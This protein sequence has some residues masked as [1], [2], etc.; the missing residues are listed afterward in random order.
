MTS[1]A[2][3]DVVSVPDSPVTTPVTLPAIEAD[4]GA[5]IITAAELLANASDPDT[6]DI[7]SVT[8]VTIATGSGTLVDNLNGTWSYTPV[9][10]DTTA[11][12]FSYTVTDG[13]LSVTGSASL[14]ITPASNLPPV[15]TSNGGA[16]TAAV[17]VAENSTAVTTVT[18]TDADAGTTLTYSISGG[19]DADLF[20]I[21]ASGV[22]SFVSAP[23]FEAPTD[24]GANNVYDVQVQV[25]DGSL[26]DTQDIAVTVTNVVE[27]GSPPVITSNGGGPTAAVSVAE[28]STAVTTVT[29]TD[30]DAGATLTYSI[31]GGADADLFA[32]N[33]SGVLSFVSAPDF[34][35]PTDAGGNN[36]YDVQ[37]QV[38][39]G[40]LTDTQDIAVTVTNLNDNAPVITSNGGAATAAVNVAENSTAV[41]TVTATDADAGTTLTYSI[42]GGADADL[43]AINASGVLSFVS[44]PDFEAPTDAG[45]NNVYDVQ[46]QVSDGSLTDTQDIAVTV[47]NLNDNAPVITSNGGAATAA[48][49]VAE[50]STA[51]TTVTATDADAGT[52]LTYS[53]SGGADA[54]LFAINASGVLSFVSAPDFEAPTDAGANNVYDV[55]V[56]VSDGSLTDT[57]DIAVTVTNLNDNAPVITSNG[58]AAT[59]AVNVAENSTAVTTVTATDA[60]AGT[61]LTY[62]ISG[63]ADADLFTINASGVL[64]FV[65]APDFEAP[66]DAGANNV[67]DVQ[68]QVSDG[69]LTDTQDIAV[70]VTNV[71]EVGS[72]PVITSNGGG[73][74]AA[75]SVAENSTAVTTVTATD[76]DAGATLTYSISGGADADQFTINATSGVLSFVS[77]PDFEAPT[78]AGANNV[79][80]VQVQVSDGSL[81]DTQDIAV[82]VTNLNDNAP[83]ITSNGGAATAAVNVAENSTAVTTVTA[84]DADAGTTL[85][86]SISG[87]A[88]ADL[89]TINASGVL[90][91][92]SAPDFE[93]PT[94][95]GAN[96]V[97]D[98]QVQVSD[99]SLTDTQDIAVTVT[100]VVEVGSPPVITSNGGGPTAAVSVAEN[101]TAVTTVTATDADAG[102]TLTYSIS[103]GADADQFTINATSGVL[104][105]VSAPDFEAPT[106]AGANNVYDVQVQVSDGSLTDTQD[107]AVTVTN[108]NDNAPVITSNGGAATAAVN[109]AENSTAVTTVTATDADA[110][111]TLTYSISGGADAD[112]FT[113]NASGVLSF[114]SAPDF[115]A[116]TD[117][118]ANNVYDVQ[119][120]VSD[121][122]LT[123]TQD[124]A[125]TV[126]NLN[127]NAPVITSNGGAATAAVNVAENS[128]AVT[129][130]TATDADAGATLTYSISG[131]ADA[132][133]FTINATSGVLSFVSAPDFEAPTDAGANNVYDVQ[134]Q[135]SDGSLT[136]TQD[137]AVTVTNVVEVG[138]P[139]VITSNGG[140]PTAAVS[141]AEN[142]TAVTTVTATDADAGA[143]LTYSISGG[144]DADL[145]AINAERCPELCLG[146]GLRSPHRRRRQQRL[147]RPGPGLGWFIDRHPGHRRHRHQPQRQCPGD[148][149]QRRRRDRRRQCRREQ[150]RRHH[151]DRHRRRCRRH[152]DL[153]DQRRRRCRPVHHQCH[154]RC[155]ELCLG[156]GLRSPHRR[157]RQQR[158]RRPGPGLGW[159]ID[160]HPGH[161]RHRHQ[162]QRQCPGDHLQRR[163]RDRR[164]QR[165]REQ[166]RRHHR[167]RH[168]RRCR[169]HPDL[170]DQRRR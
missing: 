51:V 40:S 29:A 52:T 46:V 88:D 162:P 168:R 86:Y 14:D 93:A 117:A 160:R 128:T 149:L 164:R 140:G 87:G 95:A 134:V 57:Q 129:T 24:A 79:Y 39:D 156:S 83:V 142:S 68:V 122:S 154:E 35:A 74:T 152:P 1:T 62:S 166:H 71:V 146:S 13:E 49:N 73:P 167:D 136:D 92:V 147:R 43:F 37:V 137:I 25:S 48:V 124:I 110:G 119:V 56:Q 50:N 90:S 2:I 7:L 11:V 130:V 163:R 22:L 114:V 60:D 169:R 64:S 116:P 32:I 4:S 23:D 59:A 141:V 44:A 159:F 126:T 125:V 107:I 6:G 150:H 33:A 77:A 131:G 61:T 120:Q 144:A 145:F 123:D 27:V 91:F 3:L 47:T 85:T 58:G 10:G 38:S 112:L 76:A 81:T 8:G 20:A 103:G 165:R 135:V 80:D 26:T 69:S 132:D 111:T 78:D 5:H 19:A 151:R 89:F 53:I 9:A 41:T 98:V 148:H 115:E 139:P 72:P 121:G 94:D 100:N 101:S 18:A 12:S 118:G 65:S 158:L 36:V 161:R 84:T 96:N 75:V 97:Y 67:Y 42:S 102:A 157:R 153:F 105:F 138:N 45:A 15:I 55:Q 104:S 34:E 17:N 66:T 109:V 82:T 28:N 30:A 54:D 113:I 16:A 155:P 127:D 63:G 108:L 21:N 106:D 99:G 170:F 143:T 31:S 70:T 133:Q